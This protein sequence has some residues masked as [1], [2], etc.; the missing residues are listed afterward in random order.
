ML[1]VFKIPLEIT[2]V[3][4]LRSPS[5]DS[6]YTAS[7]EILKGMSLLNLRGEEELMGLCLCHDYHGL[8]LHLFFVLQFNYTCMKKSIL[9]YLNI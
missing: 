4:Q 6:T 8:Y 9:V 7:S 3:Y 2:D 1:E 5:H